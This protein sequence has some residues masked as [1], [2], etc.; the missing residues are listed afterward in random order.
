[1][2]IKINALPNHPRG[3]EII[4][5][6]ARAISLRHEKRHEEA[7]G[8]LEEAILI[9]PKFFP[10]LIEKG[11]ILF[12][13]GRY[14]EAIECFDLF[15]QCSGNSQVRELRNS[16]LKHALAICERSIAEGPPNIDLLLKQGRPFTA[17]ATFRRCRVYLQF[18]FGNTG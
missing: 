6:I 18:C 3:Q 9:D 10:M 11:I 2:D 7:L 13:L 8:C 1:M 12:E 16:C 15:L 17:P 4:D 14:N 5:L